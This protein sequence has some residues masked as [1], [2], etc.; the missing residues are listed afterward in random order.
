MTARSPS[1]LCP[2]LPNAPTS[3]AAFAQRLS[4][5]R[6][7][8]H[9]LSSQ[10]SSPSGL[11]PAAHWHLPHRLSSHRFSAAAAASP[12]CHLRQRCGHKIA[13]FVLEMPENEGS[14]G[15]KRTKTSILCSK[16]PKTGV[17]KAK[18]AQKPR[19][20]DRKARKRGFHP[21]K[22]HKNLDFVLERIGIGTGKRVNWHREAQPLPSCKS[23]RTFQKFKCLIT[24]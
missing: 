23:P 2:K 18:S 15:Q 21:P 20:C 8:S 12:Q 14:E 3:A 22:K 10:R 1:F 17:Q 6:L 4:S 16:R 24:R 7:S 13:L 9:R 19:F 5:Q 11:R